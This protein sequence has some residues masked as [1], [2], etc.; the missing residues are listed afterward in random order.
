MRSD[1]IVNMV[2]ACPANLAYSPPLLDGKGLVAKPL[3]RA[4]KSRG[5]EYMLEQAQRLGWEGEGRQGKGGAAAPPQALNPLLL[6]PSL[7][8]PMLWLMLQDV[9]AGLSIFW[10]EM[11][12]FLL[13]ILQSHSYVATQ[14]LTVYR[15]PASGPALLHQHGFRNGT[16]GFQ[17]QLYF[18]PRT[19]CIAKLPC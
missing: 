4:Q 13:A 3:R 2:H 19:T 11:L 14:M 1:H 8:L 10:A 17:A 12:L 5:T 18:C 15:S 16:E 7:P 9:M 6:L